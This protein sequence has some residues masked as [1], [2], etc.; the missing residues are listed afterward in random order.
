MLIRWNRLNHSSALLIELEKRFDPAKAFEVIIDEALQAFMEN[1]PRL[2][3]FAKNLKL[4]S[5]IG[6]C[7]KQPIGGEHEENNGKKGQQP[8]SP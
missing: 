8:N 7:F 1:Y 3:P 4:R 2:L 5:Q 6:D